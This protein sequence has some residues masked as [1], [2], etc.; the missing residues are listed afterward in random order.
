[1]IIDWDWRRWSK[2][3]PFALFLLTVRIASP[4]TCSPPHPITQ[5]MKQ[6]LMSPYICSEPF[7]HIFA[8]LSVVLTTSYTHSV[9]KALKPGQGLNDR[10]IDKYFGAELKLLAHPK[11]NFHWTHPVHGLKFHHHRGLIRAL[12]GDA[13]ADILA[14][15]YKA[16]HWAPWDKPVL[17]HADILF[18]RLHPEI[19]EDRDGI[20]TPASLPD[21][22][23][24]IRNRRPPVS[25]HIANERYL[26][27]KL[28]LNPHLSQYGR[29]TKGVD[30]E[31]MDKLAASCK[32]YQDQASKL[33]RPRPDLWVCAGAVV[34]CIDTLPESEGG[35]TEPRRMEWS[36]EDFK[37]VS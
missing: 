34:R 7:S 11:L 24:P 17:R 19:P 22:Y 33:G 25:P 23:Y 21:G 8:E 13:D 12:A 3:V 15:I 32:A 26:L 6:M 27:W 30:V 20:V 10:D 1:M 36:P 37:S 31:V 9:L 5:P 18:R 28:G 35:V 29:D 16:L 4:R 2:F 14:I